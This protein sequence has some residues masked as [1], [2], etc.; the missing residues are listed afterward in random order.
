MHG[1]TGTATTALES[2]LQAEPPGLRL[3]VLANDRFF[4]FKLPASG[5]VCIGRTSSASIA[6]DHPAV[7]RQHARLRLG[8]AI[9][10]TDLDSRNGTYLGGRRLEPGRSELLRPGEVIGIGGLRLVVYGVPPAREATARPEVPIRSLSPSTVLLDPKMLQLYRMAT[11]VAA[12]NISVLLIGETGTGKEV[13]AEA[14]HLNSPRRTK[15]LLRLNCAALSETLLE[16]E[17]FGHE[18][19]AFTGATTAKLGLLE[20]AQGGTV[21]LDEIGEMPPGLQA[22]L[23][24]VLEDRVVMRVGGLRERPID[25]RFISATNRN[26]GAE[27]ERNRF[28]R[29]L[30]YR[31]NGATLQ[32]P[33]L[34]ERQREIEPLARL[35]L[36]KVALEMGRPTPHISPAALDRL[37][38]HRWPGNVREL[39]NV[40]ERAALLC[41]DQLLPEHLPEPPAT[42]ELVPDPPLPTSH[43]LTSV[44]LGAAV[45]GHAQVV[46]PPPPE[47]PEDAELSRILQA[48]ERCAGN[49]T[50][51]ARLLGIS[52]GTLVSRLDIYRVPRPRKPTRFRPGPT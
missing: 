1:I 12:G 25:A 9:S 23:L 45:G 50:Q 13:L 17:L 20:T 28:R 24:R 43:L 35:F 21:F 6:I 31:L 44:E 36:D 49:Q 16:S 32:I 14:I 8:P 2:S 30:Y 5:E 7:S 41:D 52:R 27:S 4:D 3:T 19:G 37:L 48:L 11:S 46:P 38:A 33:P 10:I 34:R 29:D 40:M 22:K 26:I 47:S 39:R 42:A 18:K 15:P 51:A